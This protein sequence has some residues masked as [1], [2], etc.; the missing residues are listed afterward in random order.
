M[1][2]L[3]EWLPDIN[4]LNTDTLDVARNIFPRA[5]SY[6]P[7]SSLL[8]QSLSS[9]PMACKGIWFVQKT[10][11]GYVTYAATAQRI[12]QYNPDTLAFDDVSRIDGGTYSCPA[13]DYWSGHPYGNRFILTNIADEP[14]YIDTDLG[15]NFDALPGNPPRARFITVIDDRVML[16]NLSSDPR[17]I[18]WSDINN[19]EEWV[20]GLADQQEFP[21][22]GPVQGVFPHARMI[23][24]ERGTRTIVSTND[25]LSFEFPELATQK[26]TT[27]PWASVEFGDQLFWLS[28]D[29]FYVGNANGHQNFS[30]NKITRYFFETV[31]RNRIAQTFGTFDPFAPRIYFAYPSE[32]TDYNNRILVYDRS[33]NRF[34]EIVLDTYVLA[35][36]A[37]AGITLES[38]VLGTDLD[39]PGLPSFDSRLFM[40]GAPILVAVGTNLKLSTLAGTPLEAMLETCTYELEEDRRS[41]LQHVSLRGEGTGIAEATVKVAKM[42]TLDQTP[43]F[44]SAVPRQVSG[45]HKLNHDAAFHRLRWTIP[46]EADWGNVSGWNER[47]IP[48]SER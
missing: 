13:D 45:R 5:N 1:R 34:S 4:D 28:E 27:A 31:N 21:D 14:Q 32:D 46:A 10:D 17:A 16:S 41:L 7:V 12:Y 11:G 20:L 36:L 33:L 38:P 35:R 2:S 43:A 3:G 9:L 23:L 22:H 44:G 47:H 6:G 19:S 40:A 15:L 29:G 39:A 24:L 26:G 37:T 42:S 48:T 18:A 8:A 30:D 25:I